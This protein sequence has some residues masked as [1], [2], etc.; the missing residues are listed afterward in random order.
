MTNPETLVRGYPG[1]RYGAALEYF[2]RIKPSGKAD[3]LDVG[4]F[5]GNT[6]L[7]EVFQ[8]LSLPNIK[9]VSINLPNEYHGRT[10]DI[11][12]DSQHLPIK[13]ESIPVVVA[14]DVL[15]HVEREKRAA[16]IL[17]M[18]RVAQEKVIVSCPF[19]SEQ[20]VRL[21]E[22]LLRTME[23]KGLPPKASILQ[24]RRQGLPTLEELV[25]MA[26][27]TN[28]PFSIYPAT[29]ALRDFMGLNR[30]IE[31]IAQDELAWARHM[32]ENDDRQL[33]LRSKVNWQDAYRAVLVI[34]KNAKGRIIEDKKELFIGDER[35]AYRAALS[36]AGFGLIEDPVLFYSK[37]PLR[38]RHIVFEGPEGSGKTTIMR[39]V[40]SLL[41][42]WGYTVGIPTDFGRRQ[43]IRDM[44]RETGELI[45]EP[46]RGQYFA[47]AMVESTITGNAHTLTG[48]Y[49]IALSD[50]SLTSVPMHKQLYTPGDQTIPMLLERHAPHNKPDLTIVLQV[51]DPNLNFEM[52]Q[53]ER[54]LANMN[55]TMA[56]LEYQ[57]KYYGS[58]QNNFLSGNRI[59]F[60]NNP[61]TEGSIET[62]VQEVL[63]AIEAYCGIPTKKFP[64]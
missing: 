29:D 37:N 47:N 63:A 25:A 43:D 11:T 50:R 1:S 39:I 36:Q 46:Q 41:A 45:P 20:N 10:G 18:L 56:Q 26:R 64:K 7:D 44:E 2:P 55:R 6:V 24:H 38:G 40:A 8:E 13:S 9:A 62:V 19:H 49:S 58:L 32:A 34:D 5:R 61:G 4:G 14:V 23:E 48:P 35:T 3:V 22:E 31:A 52:M 30:Q 33:R 15:E 57:R 60:I 51:E 27:L 42:D 54:D 59:Y 12:Y 28:L 16:L 21:E 53:R 17:E